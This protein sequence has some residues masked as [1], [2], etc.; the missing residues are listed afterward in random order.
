[1]RAPADNAIFTFEI[2]GTGSTLNEAVENARRHVADI[3]GALL[4][5]GL[6]RR[7]L[8]TS[9]FHSGENFGGKAFLSKSRD[10]KTNITVIVDI[11]S[12]Q[13]LEPAVMK[14]SEYKLERISNIRFSHKNYE[15]LKE[16]AL[17]RAIKKAKRKAIM[18]ASVMETKLGNIL[19]IE[20]LYPRSASEYRNYP[21]PFNASIQ[22]PS[23]EIICDPGS[24]DGFYA[25]EIKLNAKVK[26]II[27]L[28]ERI[29]KE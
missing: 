4:E 6:T 16:E 24:I 2:S 10:Y 26:V 29:V 20:E 5:I 9:L 7:N 14:V 17:E 27:E 18:L 19:H 15:G 12:L 8:R 13:F 25:Q 1:M 23:E 3:S 28:G 11:D 21:N 22:V